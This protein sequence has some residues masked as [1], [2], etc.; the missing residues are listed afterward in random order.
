MPVMQ[1]LGVLVYTV[2]PN[3]ESTYSES[4]LVSD[5]RNKQEVY[6]LSKTGVIELESAF[7]SKLWDEIRLQQ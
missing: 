2:V 5:N 4:V 1:Q 7:N 3:E 6:L